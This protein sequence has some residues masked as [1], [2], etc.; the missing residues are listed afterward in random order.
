MENLHFEWDPVKARTNL[1][2]HRVH[3]GDAVFALND[4]FA[5]TIPDQDS[6]AEERWVTLGKDGFGRLLVVVWT[7]RGE[8]IR[9]IS[10]RLATA[11][12]RR[13]YEE[14]DET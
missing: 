8:N 11:R 4:E 2:K 10:A 14:H 3:F 12:E 13:R 1:A 6:E 7:W 5:L 9:L